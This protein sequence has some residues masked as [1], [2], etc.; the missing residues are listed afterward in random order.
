MSQ[1]KSDPPGNRFGITLA[2]T[3][4]NRY[5]C[6]VRYLPVG[7]GGSGT[8]IGAGAGEGEGEGEGEGD[9]DGDGVGEGAGE[10]STTLLGESGDPPPQPDNRPYPRAP[11]VCMKVLRVLVVMIS[12]LLCRCC[13]T[14]GRRC[15]AWGKYRQSGKFVHPPA[16]GTCKY[17]CAA[18]ARNRWKR[19]GMH[20]RRC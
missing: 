10:G 3:G 9:G 11:V 18:V 16:A 5:C 12:G 2:L 17:L 20:A 15:G 19:S 8:G 7:A 14:P 6:V 4:W 1:P 13:A